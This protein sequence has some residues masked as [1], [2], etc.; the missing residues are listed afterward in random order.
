[1][2]RFSANEPE[3]IEFSSTEIRFWFHLFA[4]R[5]A[6]NRRAPTNNSRSAVCAMLLPVYARNSHIYNTICGKSKTTRQVI[7]IHCS[8]FKKMQ[9]MFSSGEMGLAN[10]TRSFLLTTTPSTTAAAA[11]SIHLHSIFGLS[12]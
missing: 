11:H 10:E 6:H 2:L 9:M 4:T 3:G 12:T 1:M 8:I 7:A 5:P